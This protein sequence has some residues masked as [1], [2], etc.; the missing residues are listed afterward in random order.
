VKQ[1]VL[2][3]S[4][5]LSWCFADQASPATDL[6]LDHV[7]DFGAVV[8]TLWF[9]EVASVLLNAER[10]GR[11]TE[12]DVARRL[13]LISALP[14]LVDQAGTGRA[15]SEIL[16]LARAEKL[17]PYDACYLDLALRRALPLFTQDQELAEAA[18]RLGVEVSP[19]A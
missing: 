15:W 14:I 5:T 13:E 11:I 9:V 8:P 2:D 16:P 3:A 1:A 12:P 6:L 4:V 10:R 17:T 7:R 18:R 19:R